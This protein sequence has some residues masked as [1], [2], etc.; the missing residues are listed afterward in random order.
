MT[1]LDTLA[2][3]SANAVHTSVSGVRAPVAGIGGAAQAAAFWRMASYAAAGAAAGA[4]VV[5]A[6]LVAG[7]TADDPA[8]NVVPT[9]NV[10]VPTT[11]VNAV[12][13]PT[14]G[15]PSPTEEPPP[16]AP[17]PGEAVSEPA[18]EPEDV[19]PPMLELISPLD[20][21][22][23]DMRIVTFS[24]RT[25]LGAA[26]LASGKF[27]V[28]VDEKGLWSVELVLA[29]GANGVVFSATDSAHNKSE[30][31]LT[32]YFDVEDSEVEEPLATTTTTTTVKPEEETVATTTAVEWLFSANQKYGSC[33]EPVPFDVFNGRAKPGTIVTVSS[34]FGGGT[35][36]VNDDGAWT[37]LV[38]FPSAPF[39]EEFL[40]TVTDHGGSQKVFTFISLY[41]G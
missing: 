15:T 24:G 31:R 8:E 5:V 4:A 27:P 18:A 37:R 23:L 3:S 6:L 13:T 32:V 35:T 26:M 7:P 1:T 20:G 22:H 9:T 34:P 12:V 10:A 29:P 41:E 2:L 19:E 14:T 16:V 33:S 30:I 21:D 11:I 40:V 25:E 28:A 36:E 39:N 38:E 17:V